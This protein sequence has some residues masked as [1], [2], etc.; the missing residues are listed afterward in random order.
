[1][2]STKRHTWTETQTPV[3]PEPEVIEY[4]MRKVR[5]SINTAV[6]SRD[7]EVK[8]YIVA[9]KTLTLTEQ[10]E[11]L[12]TILETDTTMHSLA[13]RA[14]KA[15]ARVLELEQEKTTA[16]ANEMSEKEVENFNLLVRRSHRLSLIE[17]IAAGGGL[18]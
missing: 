14:I 2:T 5:F 11:I 8:D 12:H 9:I 13:E 17:N 10:L 15:E 4:R 1:M 6:Q 3:Q 16:K 18:K 7:P